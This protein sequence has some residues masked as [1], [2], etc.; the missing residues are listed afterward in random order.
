MPLRRHHR[1][2]PR[3]ESE[4]PHPRRPTMKR[5]LVVLAMALAV[6]C[7]SATK[8][9]PN[10]TPQA[11][12]AWYGTQVIKVIDLLRDTAVDANHVTPPLLSTDSTRRLVNWHR[13]ALDVVHQ[14]P[15]GW[16]NA[17]STGL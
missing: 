12:T 17:V 11:T 15:A 1:R 10:L 7:T 5:W 4:V 6:S 13:S 3:A 2:A 14:A 8:A 9:P 16:P